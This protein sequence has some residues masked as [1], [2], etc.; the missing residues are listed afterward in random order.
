MRRRPE[1]A[2][3]ST[4]RLRTTGKPSTKNTESEPGN[5]ELLAGPG[6]LNPTWGM[7]KG[8]TQDRYRTAPSQFADVGGADAVIGESRFLGENFGMGGGEGARFYDIL[9]ML[10]DSEDNTPD[11]E[12][13]IR[14]PGLGYYGGL[15]IDLDGDGEIDH[16]WTKGGPKP[17]G[18]PTHIYGLKRNVDDD[19]IPDPR[20]PIEF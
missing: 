17:T 9:Q 19:G 6:G 13:G 10:I 8:I 16:I 5:Q 15:P 2:K 3:L 12:T 1:Y 20:N 11:P 14:K 4:R 18:Q 7:H